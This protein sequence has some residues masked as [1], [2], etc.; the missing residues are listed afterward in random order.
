MSDTYRIAWKLK[1]WGDGEGEKTGRSLVTY[2]KVE[3]IRYAAEQSE[4]GAI[5]GLSYWPELANLCPL[6]SQPSDSGAPHV[7][8]ADREQAMADRE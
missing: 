5:I 3:A 1:D 6:C 2:S 4:S 8:C 7:D